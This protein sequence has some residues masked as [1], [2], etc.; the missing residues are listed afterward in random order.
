MDESKLHGRINGRIQNYTA[1]FEENSANDTKEHKE[2]RLQNY[3]EV[4]NGYYDGATELYEFGWAKSFHFSRFYRG[5]AFHQS[6]A[7]H[8]HY[9]AAQMHLRPGMRVLDVGCGVGGPAREIARFSGVKIVG[10]N[11]N[12]FQIHRARG[13]TEKAGLSSDIQF[14][15]GDFMKLCD[16]FG[17]ESF[18]A[19]YAIEATVHAPSFEGIYGE[20]LKVLKPGGIFGVYEW[21]MT[22]AW[23]PSIPEHKEIAH[24]IEIGDGIA[25]MRTYADAKKAI[26][27]V[28]YNVLFEEDL[29]ERPDEV[30][31]Y[32]PLE[33]DLSKAQTTWDYFTVFRMTPLG[34][35]FT[36]N[37]IWL[38]E[39]FHLMPKGTWEVCEQ[40]KLAA[41]G[42][43]RGG[44]TKLFT[45]MAL[46]IA[47]KPENKVN[48]VHP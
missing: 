45:P 42:L 2:N 40:L 3:T 19:V 39:L 12:A 41:L 35:F 36:H 15:Q 28:G 34:I 9:L 48:G 13:Y 23:D 17:P 10:I 4:V 37:I 1:F 33:G 22:D 8:E 29:A 27:S 14:V 46:F 38:L 24:N 20:I 18:D 31:W 47:Q 32:Y 26:R 16:I 5:E 44:Q 30:P 7:R 11:N 21:V 6:L 43:T 25:E